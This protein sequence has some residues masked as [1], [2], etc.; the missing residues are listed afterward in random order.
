[1]FQSSIIQARMQQTCLNPRDRGNAYNTFAKEATFVKSQIANLLILVSLERRL[2]QVPQRLNVAARLEAKL[3]HRNVR[4]HATA[5]WTPAAG[6][7][8]WLAVLARCEHRVDAWDG[9][10]RGRHGSSGWGC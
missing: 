5:A 9:L 7:D 1:L 8:G 6:A 2:V 10:A 3:V 4:R